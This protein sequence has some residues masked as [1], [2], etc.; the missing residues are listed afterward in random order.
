M[1]KKITQLPAAT[2]P[3]TGLKTVVAD[4]N[5]IAYKTN[6]INPVTA[7]T[8]MSV[9]STD[10]YN[11]IV[12]GLGD[13]V[14]D[15]ITEKTSGHGINLLSKV[16]LAQA[17]QT[18]TGAGAITT[19]NQTTRW[20]TTGANAATLAGG[21]AATHGQI[22]IIY[23]SAHGGDGTLT[24][25]DVGLF[26]SIVFTAVGQAVI[27]YYNHPFGWIIIGNNGCTITL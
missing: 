23:M 24:L 13:V 4:S 1:N 6:F 9:D 7:G 16:R 22:K 15:S 11:P 27:L 2:P 12:N 20:V 17:E 18:L 19:T 25:V 14:L 26:T 8:N 10:P 5:G 3:L 21:S